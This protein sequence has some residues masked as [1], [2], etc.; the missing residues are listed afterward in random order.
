MAPRL[1]GTVVNAKGRGEE[2]NED[3]EEEEEEEALQ[4]LL[5]DKE[6]AKHHGSQLDVDAPLMSPLLPVGGL[7]LVLISSTRL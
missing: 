2:E 4:T 5:A 6:V 7:E 1:Y 3:E